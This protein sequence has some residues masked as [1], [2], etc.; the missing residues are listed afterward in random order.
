MK[1]IFFSSLSAWLYFT[2]RAFFAIARKFS[3]ELMKGTGNDGYW[4]PR[5]KSRNLTNR[6]SYNDLIKRSDIFSMIPMK[7]VA[8]WHRALAIRT[9]TLRS[10]IVCWASSVLC[11]WARDKCCLRD[12]LKPSAAMVENTVGTTRVALKNRQLRSDCCGYDR[13]YE[14]K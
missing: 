12:S 3:L 4:Q 5:P 14:P 6:N 8:F 13:G 11:I 7:R 2:V 10:R 1:M 9:P